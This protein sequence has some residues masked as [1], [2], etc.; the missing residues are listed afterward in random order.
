MIDKIIKLYKDL[1]PK[2][3][4]YINAL[5]V[6]ITMIIIVSII[7][8]RMT[9]TKIVSSGKVVNDI[10]KIETA[11]SK[12]DPQTTWRHQ[13]KED[14]QKLSE[15]VEE[16][17]RII[18]KDIIDREKLQNQNDLEKEELNEE[19]SLLR[20]T[21]Q[22]ISQKNSELSNP[23]HELNTD[24]AHIQTKLEINKFS[25]Q[26]DEIKD[27]SPKNIDD[28]I[29]AGAF[30]KGII[31]GGVDSSTAINAQSE[32]RP[33]LIRIVDH[34]TL[35]RRFKSDLKDC[36]VI[37]S[38]YGDLSSERVYVR[39]EKLSCVEIASGEIT[40]TEIGGYVAGEDSKVGIR[41]KVIEKGQKYIQNS[42][43]G[44]VLQGVAGIL[45]PQNNTLVSPIGSFENKKTSLERFTQGATEGASGSMDRLSKYYISKAETITPVIE[46]SGGRIV[47]IVFTEGAQIGTELVK[48]KLEER[49]EKKDQKKN[50]YLDNFIQSSGTDINQY[51]R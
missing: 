9:S 34:G 3:Q 24:I 42:I 8:Y 13:T 28:T 26:L 35:P 33:M 12:T 22:Q 25:L 43:V 48:Q 50:E 14:I 32:P 10:T 7:S 44:G 6:I 15:S 45:S 40:E 39:L 27:V 2:I 38:S 29:P 23:N 31:I 36:H 11:I 16:L 51:M 18:A 47:D 5:F 46:V 4:Q 21:I 49:R 30:A 17:Q 19:I 37:A 1:N 20:E 41:G